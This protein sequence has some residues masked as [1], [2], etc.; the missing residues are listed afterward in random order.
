MIVPHADY[1]KYIETNDKFQ[2]LFREIHKKADRY[3]DDLSMLGIVTNH[4]LSIRFLKNKK[5]YEI[6]VLLDFNKPFEFNVNRIVEIIK[7]EEG[8][9]Q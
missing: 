1:F 3:V 7:K 4:N 8:D 2:K 6:D 9:K 5:W